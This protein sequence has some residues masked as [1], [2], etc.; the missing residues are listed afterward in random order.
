MK[1]NMQKLLANARR[2]CIRAHY[3]H[4]ISCARFYRHACERDIVL[5]KAGLKT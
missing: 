1:Y 2:E 4:S 3:R 5:R